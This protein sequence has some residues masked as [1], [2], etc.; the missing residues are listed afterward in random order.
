MASVRMTDSQID[1]YSQVFIKSTEVFL[2]CVY[3]R[4]RCWG[5]S[6][7]LKLWTKCSPTITDETRRCHGNTSEALRASSATI[8]V[9]LSCIIF[10][11]S[12]ALILGFDLDISAYILGHGIVSGLSYFISTFARN[13]TRS[14]ADDNKADVRYSGRTEPPKMP[15][16]E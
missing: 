15:R 11:L 3:Q 6:R 4:P 14:A 9:S 12:L 10:L 7:G 8:P 5:E 1:R 16:L 2:M 13:K